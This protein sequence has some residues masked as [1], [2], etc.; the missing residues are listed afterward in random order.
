MTLSLY[1]IINTS[2]NKWQCSHNAVWTEKIVGIFRCFV[3]SGHEVI[4]NDFQVD[5]SGEKRSAMVTS[6][7]LG[8][9]L[10]KKI[11]QL[12]FWYNH[13]SVFQMV[14]VFRM[15][16]FRLFSFLLFCWSSTALLARTAFPLCWDIG[17]DSPSLWTSTDVVCQNHVRFWYSIFLFELRW[18]SLKICSLSKAKY[19]F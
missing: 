10:I 15:C 19:F 17:C 9:T 8:L 16:V 6:E 3:F 14:F 13:K 11:V 12:V 2:I 18:W 7:T 4:I 5:L 1:S